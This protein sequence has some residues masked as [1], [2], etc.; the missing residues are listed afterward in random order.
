MLII[1]VVH[2]H[3]CRQQSPCLVQQFTCWCHWSTTTKVSSNSESCRSSYYRSQKIE[4]MT[5]ILRDL[6]WL[7]IRRQ[8]TVKTFVMMY[9]CFSTESTNVL[10]AVMST[11]TDPIVICGLDSPHWSTDCSTYFT[12]GRLQLLWRRQSVPDWLRQLVRWPNYMTERS[13]GRVDSAAQH[14]VF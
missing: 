4:H 2:E 9:K 14:K 7:P 12:H 1:V 8:I 10:S 3:C 5:L 6:H 11:C 13:R